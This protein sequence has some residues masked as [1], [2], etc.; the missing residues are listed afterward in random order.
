VRL[1][2]LDRPPKGRSGALIGDEVLDFG[3]AGEVFPLATWIP[4]D[5][6]D[7]IA[8]GPEGLD[9]VRKLVDRVANATE[10]QKKSLRDIGALAPAK[11][12]R[13]R[14][15]VR[16]GIVFSHGRAYGSHRAE[17]GSAQRNP[18][19]KPGGF[20]KNISSVIGTGAPIYVPPQ[21]PDMLDFEGEISVVFG[22][23][24]HNVKAKDALDHIMG[25]TIVN[26]VSARDWV[27]TMKTHGNDINR[28]GK[29]LPSF[30]P[31]GPCIATKD[32]IEDILRMH[33]VSRLNGQVM[34]DSWTDD[35]IWNLPE[36]IEYYSFWYP[37]RAG[38]VMT[39]GSPAG[40]GMGRKPP[41]FMK[42]GDTIAITV[43]GV[44]TLENPIV[45]GPA[46]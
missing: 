15:P 7:I 17:M 18:D 39:T 8:T 37:F 29:Q 41:V 1:V 13:L 25:V 34:Q 9:I 14:A 20:L 6:V 46:K 27:K 45:A 11:S 38:D 30:C 24:T 12:T 43:D 33:V 10:T 35:L 36:L 16:P 40:V 42:A 31:L 26:D 28:M 32:E 2:T 21:A 44:G 5:M 22:K 23:F 4:A 19:E 3:M